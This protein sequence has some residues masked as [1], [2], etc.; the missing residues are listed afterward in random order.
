METSVIEYK[1]D[2]EY[3]CFNTENVAYVFELEEYNKTTSFHESVQGIVKYNNDTMLLIDTAILFGKHKMNMDTEKSVI[4][5]QDT[6]TKEKYGMM[7]DEIIKLEDVHNSNLS[8]NLNKDNIINHY[9]SENNED[10]I[11]EIFPLPLLQK[12]NIPAMQSLQDTNTIQKNT[13]ENSEK[14]YYLIIRINQE[15]YAIS[16]QYVHEVLENE[17][18]MFLLKES[19]TNIKG[20]ISIRNEIIQVID[21]E[22]TQNK[23]D[24]VILSYKGQKLALEVDEIYDIENLSL[25]KIKYLDKQTNAIEAFY[26]HNEKVIALINPVYYFS[27]S[28][29]EMSESDLLG[30]TKNKSTEYKELLIFY[31]DSQKYTIPMENVRQVVEIDSLAKTH[32][33]A[34]GATDYIEFLATWNNH[35]VSV[36]KL[37]HFLHVQTQNTDTQVIFIENNKK[38]IAFLVDNIEN[39]VYVNQEDV[40]QID[41]NEN[42]IISGT[43][44]LNEEILVTLNPLFLTN[45]VL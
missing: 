17:Y 34:V 6:K 31:I 11:N 35:A 7:V 4:V 30:A 40:S 37:D 1:I 41:N 22:Q 5:I 12:Y 42:F 8:V 39:I 25:E 28:Q 2:N 13:Q 10:I 20:A 44:S 32:S 3:Y 24:I 43:V 33:S 45:L 19:I 14:E 18:E 9:Q 26:S 29:K 36:L 23:N 38:L 15:H 21:F 16:S 27:E